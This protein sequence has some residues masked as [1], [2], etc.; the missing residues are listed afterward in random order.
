MVE[1]TENRVG[2]GT[3]LTPQEAQ[4][5]HKQF[6]GGFLGFTVVAVIAHVLVWIWR[7]WL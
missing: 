7:P 6:V 4:E 1:P 2:M 5:F 3:Y